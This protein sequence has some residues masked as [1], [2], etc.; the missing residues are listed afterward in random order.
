[1]KQILDEVY[2]DETMNAYIDKIL[3]KAIGV[4][5]DLETIIEIKN[6][7]ERVIMIKALEDM[8]NEGKEEGYIIGLKESVNSLMNSLNISLEQALDILNIESSIR[9]KLL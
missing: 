2:N 5:V 4:S 3:L 6:G 7:K 8:V 1:M 9:E